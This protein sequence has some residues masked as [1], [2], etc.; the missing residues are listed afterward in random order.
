M[1]ICLEGGVGL[2]TQYVYKDLVFIWGL[3]GSV[4]GDQGQGTFDT[5]PPLLLVLTAKNT[6]IDSTK[7][8]TCNFSLNSHHIQRGIISIL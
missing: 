6:S 7:R 2:E 3:W 1:V 4:D 5:T 8:F